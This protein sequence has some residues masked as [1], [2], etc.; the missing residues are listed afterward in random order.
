MATVPNQC[1][2]DIEI[3]EGT[4]GYFK[5]GLSTYPL[6][7]GHEWVGR[8]EAVGAGVAPDLIGRLCVGEVSVGCLQD[9]CAFCPAQYTRCPQRTETGVARRDGAFSR[10]M[11]FPA[12]A[13]YPMAESVPVDVAVL[14]EPLVVAIH[15][16]E[17]ASVAASSS[18][19]VVLGDGPI[20]LLILQ[21]H[22]PCSRSAG[23]LNPS[24]RQVCLARGCPVIL[25]GATPFRLAK[26][27]ALGTANTHKKIT[28]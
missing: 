21:V 24:P 3:F 23:C 20:G 7:P 6:T 10:L 1:A 16:C 15:S 18:P 12:A 2:T 14:A 11:R 22:L 5:S 17:A 9:G 4:L 19:V 28:K 26:A 27:T 8:V 13:L 25:L